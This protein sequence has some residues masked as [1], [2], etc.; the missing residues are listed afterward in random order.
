MSR[1]ASICIRTAPNNC[2]ERRSR[3]WYVHHPTKCVYDSRSR[4]KIVS[5]FD[6]SPTTPERH[7]SR[8]LRPGPARGRPTSDAREPGISVAYGM[9]IGIDARRATVFPRR[10]CVRPLPLPSRSER[11]KMAMFDQL[12]KSWY[13]Y[14]PVAFISLHF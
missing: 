9:R 1:E 10:R 13:C 2:P 7:C 14:A 3:S 5:V 11:R 12:R 8:L 6:Y 4:R